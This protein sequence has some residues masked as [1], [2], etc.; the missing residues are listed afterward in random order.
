MTRTETAGFESIQYHY[1]RLVSD[2]LPC[3]D[4]TLD[5][6]LTNAHGQPRYYWQSSR[7]AVAFAGCGTAVELMGWGENRFETIRYHAAELFAGAID[8]NPTEPL[9]APRLFGGFAFRED[10]VPD[11]TWSDFVPAHFVLPHYQLLDL[12]GDIWLTINANIPFGENPVEVRDDLR[13][14]L[15]AKVE[16]LQAFAVQRAVEDAPNAP[17]PVATNYPMPFDIWR[18]NILDATKRMQAGELKKVVLSRV[19]EVRFDERVDV[20]AALRY[21]ADAYPDTYRFLFEPRPFHTFYGAT[22]ELLVQVNGQN[23]ETMALAGSIRRGQTQEED[24]ALSQELHNSEKDR[25]EHQL[26]VDALR[27]RMEEQTITLN[28][29]ETDIMRLSNIQHI[30]TP[31]AGI[32]KG[33]KGVLPLVEALHPTPALGGDPLDKAMAIIGEAEPV[34]RGW[35]A[36][37]IGWID[38]QMDGQFGVAIRSAVAQDQRVWMYAGAGIVAA[39]DPQKEWDETALKFRPMLD[40]LGVQR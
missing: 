23:V 36:A 25:Y 27:D 15:Q 1:G 32:L 33:R 2:S 5:D 3:P 38:Q 31:V 39:S 29:G 19:A 22:P 14:A 12:D 9:A 13:I 18:D 26:V 20:L 11:N 30:H 34:P 28:I 8:F 16:E 4:V 7:E 21:L 35:Y 24:D 40:A 6:F 37:P 10:F 17:R